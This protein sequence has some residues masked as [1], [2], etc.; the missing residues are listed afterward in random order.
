MTVA[1]ILSLV[2][3]LFGF[4]SYLVVVI[5]SH[6]AGPGLIIPAPRP[7]GLETL[8]RAEFYLCWAAMVWLFV[9]GLR[10]LTF[11]RGGGLNPYQMLLKY[12]YAKFTLAAAYVLLVI[13][14]NIGL[15]HAGIPA[16]IWTSDAT[17]WFLAM[18][19]YPSLLWLLLS[20]QAARQYYGVPASAG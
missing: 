6:I 9:A 8:L 10:V 13:D 15:I 11:K 20:S 16:S 5:L 4:M 3:G 1:G 2:L 18:C 19:A 17:F 7:V 12:V 14:G